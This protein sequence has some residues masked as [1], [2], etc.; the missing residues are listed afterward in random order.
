[1]TTM[2][3]LY[4]HRRRALLHLLCVRF[5]SSFVPVHG[6]TKDTHTVWVDTQAS[7][8][9]G[10]AQRHMPFLSLHRH[11]RQQGP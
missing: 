1:M 10:H 8:T 4:S 3:R 11:T 7:I 2:T 9:G 5:V 6:V